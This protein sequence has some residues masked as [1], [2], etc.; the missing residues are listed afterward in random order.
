MKNARKLVIIVFLFVG[1]FMSPASGVFSGAEAKAADLPAFVELATNPSGGLLNAI[2][3]G[4]A[5][6]ITEETP[7]AVKLRL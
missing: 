3:N 7:F 2:G 6:M 4:L 5:K 1:F